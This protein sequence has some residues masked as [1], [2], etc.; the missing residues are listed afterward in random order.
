MD[1]G[2]RRQLHAYVLLAVQEDSK[3]A[4]RL[5]R[6]VRWIETEER[7]GKERK[8]KERKGGRG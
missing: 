8:G 5:R 4:K 6:K 2:K 7:K 3:A 1:L